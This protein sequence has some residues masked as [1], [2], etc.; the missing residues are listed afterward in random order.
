MVEILSIQLVMLPVYITP[1][2][3]ST[4]RHLQSQVQFIYTGLVPPACS[5]IQ[6]EESRQSLFELRCSQGIQRA[7]KST[8]P[9]PKTSHP[10]AEM[11]H[12]L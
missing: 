11:I 12:L 4:K 3:K 10:K 5:D 9:F 8:F 7:E 6:K 1:L 2:C